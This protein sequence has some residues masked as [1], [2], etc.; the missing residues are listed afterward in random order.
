V[1]VEVFTNTPAGTVTSGGTDAPAS[2]TSESLTVTATVAFPVASTSATP[3]TVFHFCDIAAPS[4]IMRATVAPGGTGTGQA[5][6]VTRG[7]EG[8]T[9]VTHATGY[10]IATVITAGWL[11]VPAWIYVGSGGSAPAFAADWANFGHAGA[12][13]AFR[14]HQDGDV[15]IIGVITPS[16]GA[17]DLLVTLPSGYRPASIQF[18]PGAD[19]SAGQAGWWA[20]G[21]DGT[22]R[23]ANSVIDTD[24]YFINGKF[25]LSI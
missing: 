25:S 14:L 12:D 24:E 23:T 11:N 21:T 19:I 16:S 6:T 8:T 10:T 1:S 9:P 13:L 22:V 3:P 20:I 7:A 4:E 2:G 17:T 15:E 5:W 18:A